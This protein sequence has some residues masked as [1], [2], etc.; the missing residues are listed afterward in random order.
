M[1]CLFIKAPK[2]DQTS[3]SPITTRTQSESRPDSFASIFAASL[4]KEQQSPKP[5]HFST[6]NR[7]VNNP[8]LDDEQHDSN[9]NN[10]FKSK[11]AP[12][13]KVLEI[14]NGKKAQKLKKE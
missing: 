1:F 5:S 6:P 7:S 4:P 13:I 11:L 8:F 12:V 9:N 2:V 14:K 10:L 3:S